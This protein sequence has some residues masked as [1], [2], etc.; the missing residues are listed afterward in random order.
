MRRDTIS[1]T[2]NILNVYR[3]RKPAKVGIPLSEFKLLYFLDSG[4]IFADFVEEFSNIFL[5]LL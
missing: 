3:L 4:H 1:T 2:S 5:A